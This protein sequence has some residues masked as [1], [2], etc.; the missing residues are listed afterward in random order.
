[1]NINGFDVDKFNIH[2]IPE[3]AKYHTCPECSHDR[4]KSEEKCMSVFWDT[5]LGRCNHCG[6]QVQLHT[7]KKKNST[8]IKQ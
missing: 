8:S 7:Y 3:G 6:A 2:S 5:G 1:M 4:K